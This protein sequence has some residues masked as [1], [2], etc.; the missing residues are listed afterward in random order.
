VTAAGAVLLLGTA[1]SIVAIAWLLS[2]AATISAVI[3][4]HTTHKAQ[5]TKH[6]AR[7]TKHEARST[8][9]K[10]QS[11]KHKAQ[12][13]KHE[14]QGKKIKHKSTKH[15]AQSKNSKHT[16]GM[17]SKGIHAHAHKAYTHSQDT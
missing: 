1:N 17:Y 10:A 8:K 15:K 16:Q 11:T 7:S 4:I 5:S 6:E 2:L 12:S 13:T 9:H 14:A 3:L